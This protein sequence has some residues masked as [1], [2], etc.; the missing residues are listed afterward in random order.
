MTE[1]RKVTGPSS[2]F[3]R[4]IGRLIALVVVAVV[5]AIVKPWGASVRPAPAPVA[6]ASPIASPVATPPATARPR[7]YDFLSFGTNQPP[8][9]W[10]MWPAGNLASF[11]FAMRIDLERPAV[12]DPGSSANPT[13]ATTAIPVASPAGGHADRTVPAVWPTI[14]IPLASD[15][16]LLGINSPLGFTVRV[17]SLRLIGDDG[18][19]TT[20]H[21]V[22]GTSPWPDHFT[23]IG[24]G[25]EGGPDAMQPWPP[26]TY[27]LELGI[28]PGA[29]TR[30]VEI[31]I[32]GPA[33]PAVPGGSLSPTTSPDPSGAA[34]DP[35]P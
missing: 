25:P 35:A 3:G 13:P 24:Y 22:I 15:L 19:A 30:T 5:V 4:H 16:D 11:T 12:P 2:P 33:D 6:A 26:G 18:R 28:D 32:D 9:R 34:A 20:V 7:L 8:P 10:E 27:Q 17:E 29:V 1:L 14:R 21:A 31:V 23:I